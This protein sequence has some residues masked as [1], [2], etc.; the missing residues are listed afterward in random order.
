M[1]NEEKEKRAEELEFYIRQ[2]V[3]HAIDNLWEPDCTGHSI[4]EAGNLRITLDF[5]AG[6]WEKD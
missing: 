6:T 3:E 2:G 5:N 4:D 1:T